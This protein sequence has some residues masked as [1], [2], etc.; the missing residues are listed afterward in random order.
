MG[1]LEDNDIRA[2]AFDIDGTF[3]PLSRTNRRVFRASVFHLPFALRY[4]SARQALRREDSFLALEKLSRRENAAR[5]CLH[6]YGKSDSVTVDRF[7]SMEKRIFT[8]AYERLFC[9]IKPYPGVR[10]VLSLLKERGIEMAVLSDFPV[11]CKLRAMGID[12]F[13]PVQLSSSDVGRLKPSS[14]PFIVLSQRLG[15]EPENIL[16]VGDSILKDVEGAGHA[17]MK[18]VLISQKGAGGSSA[19]LTVRSWDE[20]KEKLFVER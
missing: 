13:F 10:E 16:Y 9:D 15:V 4:N 20:L 12:E 19:D 17:G 18:S 8:D 5:M 3:Y 11:G 14:T 7:L 1:F 6:M 2:V